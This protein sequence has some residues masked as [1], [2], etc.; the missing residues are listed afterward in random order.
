MM[1]KKS[2]NEIPILLKERVDLKTLTTSVFANTI[3]GLKN[4]KFKEVSM[5]PNTEILF[6]TH[7]GV[8]SGSLYN[9]P[10]ENDEFDPTYFFHEAIL[11]TRD[12]LLSSYIEDGAKRLVNDE[13]FLLLKD[14]TVKPYANHSNSY[15][16]AYFVLYSDAILGVSFGRQQVE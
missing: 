16:L 9:P 6:F 7:F 10:E 12:S 3:E 5:D 15:K 8:V 11:K 4:G 13:S 1:D 2:D 14:V